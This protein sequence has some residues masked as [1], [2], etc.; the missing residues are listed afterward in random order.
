M[1]V[2]GSLNTSK[3]S[4]QEARS[5]FRRFDSSLSAE[6]EW[7]PALIFNAKAIRAASDSL[8]FPYLQGVFGTAVFLLETVQ[9]VQKNRDSMKE[10]C[11]DTVD[12][13]TVIR[14]RISFH[15]DTTAIQFKVQCEEL[16]RVL[17]DVVEA[18]HHRQMKPRGFGP[19]LKEIIKSGSISDEINGFRDKIREVRANFM[20]MT[21]IDTNLGVQKAL[22]II[23]TNMVGPQVFQPI[24]NCPPPTRIFHGR[25]T[26]LDQMH[27]YF[28]QNISMQDIFVLHGLGGAGK[29]QIALKFIEEAASQFSDIFLIDT[30]TTAT[31]DT[32]LKTIAKIKSVGESASDALQ[33]LQSKQDK[34]LLFFDNADDPK[35][36]LN[37]YLPH[38]SHGH[39]LITSRNPGLCVYAG[40]H[41]PVKDMEEVD[42]IALL[43]RSAA[44]DATNHNKEIAAQVVLHYLPLA[45][46]QA[47]AFI[48]KA[49]N[50]DNY[51]AL[52]AHNR[53]RL[54]TERPAQSHDNYAWTVY[55]T[56]QISVDQLNERAKTFLQ[57]CSFLHYQG[58]SEQIFK[59][60]VNYRF[61]PSS[62]SEEELELPLKILS[63]F[64]G[65]SGVWDP[66]GFMDVTNDL[67]AYSLISFNPET[68][69]FSMHPLV[70]DWTHSTL[71]DNKY[72]PCMIAIMGMCLAGLS[73]EDIKLA[74]P[75]MLPHIDFLMRGNST[76]VPDFRIEYGKVYLFAGNPWKAEQLQSMV[77]EDRRQLLGENHPATLEAMYW[78]AWAYEHLGKLKEAEELGVVALKTRRAILGENHLDTLKTMGNLAVIYHMLGK[79]KEAEGLQVVALQ[80]WRDIFGDN[81]PETI[82]AMGNLGVSYYSMGKYMEAEALQHTV[83]EKRRNILGNNHPDT[84]HIMVTLGVI[85]QHLGKLR[86]A[87]EL[88]L[89]VVERWQNILGEN[90]PDTLYAMG[91]LSSVYSVLG[92][93]KEAEVLDLVVVEKRTN[94]LGVNH[95][96]TLLA[97]TNLASTCK[98]LGKPEEAEVL[99]VIVLEKWRTILGD[100]HIETMRTMGNLAV[101]YKT[102]GKFQEAE[103]LESEVL[104]K[105]KNVLGDKHPFT[106]HAMGNLAAT[107]NKIGKLQAAQELETVVLEKRRE[108]LGENHPDT[109]RT[110]SNLGSTFSKLG[111]WQEAEELLHE[112]LKKQTE[113]LSS[114]NPQIFDTMQYL[115]A[116]YT[117]LGKFKEAEEL[118]MTLKRSQS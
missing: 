19:R 33:W 5:P 36:D 85:Y 113:L 111:R 92:K 23:S 72:H 53:A 65:P 14:D 71:S 81:H 79:V 32:A 46:I 57:L 101:T 52:Y 68:N 96:D 11:A 69:M 94:L 75:W 16:E 29:T 17:Q 83:L 40:A 22:T 37:N 93:L 80:K 26:I 84:L 59:N 18:V 25:R 34:W 31:I 15:R 9:K 89:M 74:S 35:I 38:C 112:A 109:L 12:I 47:G 49:G 43:L 64:L 45:I 102:L 117:E 99:E 114:S 70:H 54:L 3:S 67:R 2:R 24:N 56:W 105:R 30:S 62:P 28:S 20:L 66:L 63:Q 87:E 73:E 7:L 77:L 90:H 60:A 116:T 78:L 98:R 118:N 97:I 44:Q 1:S 41:C 86:E 104:E 10:L 27:Q 55:T 51:L 108:I 107:Y 61:E 42:A 82:T 13:I 6:S 95:P 88:E 91:N 103:N 110:M 8:P 106:L 50:M 21:I 115:A 39:I 48:S 4:Q 76:V 58:I 100:N